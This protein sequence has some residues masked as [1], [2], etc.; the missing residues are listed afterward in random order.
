M[1]SLPKAIFILAGHGIGPSG[2][3]D[4]G[5][6]GNGTTERKEVIE[7]AR[8]TVQRLKVDADF[9]GVEIVGIGIDNA[10][11]LVDKEKQVNAYMKQKGY[12][13]NDAVLVD[14]HMN[15]ASASARGIEAWYGMNGDSR[16]FAQAIANYVAGATTIPLRPNP[17]QPSNANRLGRLGILDDTLPRA[18]LIECGFITNELDAAIVKDE[19]LDD[20]FTTGIVRGIRSFF[21]LPMDFD[22]KGFRDVRETDYFYKPALWAKELGIVDAGNEGMLRPNAPATRAEVLT[23]LYRY[24]NAKIPD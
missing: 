13:F 8:E 9:D 24:H 7:I 10:M 12:T 3:V 5:A 1:P 11:S 23:M 15:S 14:I 16:D 19:K 2:T 18:C 21:G 22:S 4:N 20:S 6:S 17:V